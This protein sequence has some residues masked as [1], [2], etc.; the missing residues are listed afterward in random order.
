[1][2]VGTLLAGVLIGRR[3]GVRTVTFVACALLAGA[4]VAFGAA[5]TVWQLDF[6]RWL[7]GVG[8]GGLWCALL[9]WLML[10]APFNQRGSA[11]GE[12]IG[13]SVLGT[14]SG[15]LLGLGSQLTGPLPIFAAVAAAVVILAALLAGVPA[16]PVDNTT[17]G[18]RLDDLRLP[19]DHTLRAAALIA[20]VPPLVSG[21]VITLAPVDL[22]KLGAT[23]FEIAAMLLLSSLL[24]AGTCQLAGRQAD[25][26]H[27]RAS[28][29]AGSLLGCLALVAM[30]LKT[31]W[32]TLA[33]AVVVY[34]G[35][36]LAFLWI[37]LMSLLT[38]RAQWAGMSSVGAAIVLNVTI[39]LGYTVGPLIGTGVAQ[40]V[41]FRAAYL[42]LTV[43][44]VG[45]TAVI[46]RW[47]VVAGDH[48]ERAP[49]AG[50]ASTR[51]IASATGEPAA[52]SK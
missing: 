9:N 13:A 26:A 40:G 39:S 48:L 1:M 8:S 12:A 42:V 5:A 25:R 45:L 6:A 2:V 30:V 17:A 36:A 33:V 31:G 22:A 28:M 23:R 49:S 37:P 11:L 19:P 47:S 29:V 20:L 16:P 35:I 34:G 52:G 7:Q 51:S 15:P 50:E 43:I 21:A 27:H 3:Q 24:A 14:A 10:L 41:S 18:R 46:G 4:S 32:P 38:T 44:S